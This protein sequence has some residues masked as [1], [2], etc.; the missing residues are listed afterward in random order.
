MCNKFIYNLKSIANTF[1][2]SLFEP[3]LTVLLS[4]KSPH[5]P[6]FHHPPDYDCWGP[7]A[8]AL[9]I[10]LIKIDHRIDRIYQQF[11]MS[12]KLIDIISYG[13]ARVVDTFQTLIQ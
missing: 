11:N 5:N 10:S 1:H 7:P 4:F 9:K 12:V 2:L 8:V 3:K 6:H 13:P